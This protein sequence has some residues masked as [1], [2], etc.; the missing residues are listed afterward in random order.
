MIVIS[1]CLK[2]IFYG[3]FIVDLYAKEVFVFSPKGDLYALARGSSVLDFAFKV[4]SQLGSHCL[5]AKV[6]GKQVSIKHILID[7]DTVDIIT[8]NHQSPKREWLQLVRTSKA[9]SRI[10]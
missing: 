7:G 10:R 5:G 9:K 8:S 6:N 3:I 1:P 4:H 2:N